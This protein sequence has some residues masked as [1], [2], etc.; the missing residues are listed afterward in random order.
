[1]G[2][3]TCFIVKLTASLRGHSNNFIKIIKHSPEGSVISLM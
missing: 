1:M 2:I 3:L